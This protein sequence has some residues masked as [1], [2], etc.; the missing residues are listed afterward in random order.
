MLLQD[1]PG[2]VAS[3]VGRIRDSIILSVQ[4]PADD[5]KDRP[6][7]AGADAPSAS[8]RREIDVNQIRVAGADSSRT[9]GSLERG[10]DVI[11]CRHRFVPLLSG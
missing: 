8:S 11:A 1:L 7:A 10:S 2:A 9:Q 6:S 4:R 3:Q 5:P